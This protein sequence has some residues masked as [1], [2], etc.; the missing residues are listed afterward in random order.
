V[1]QEFLLG[2]KVVKVSNEAVIREFVR[3][4]LHGT[5]RNG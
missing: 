3:I 2:K 5:Q 1:A 4:F